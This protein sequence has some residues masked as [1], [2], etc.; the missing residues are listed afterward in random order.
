MGNTRRKSSVQ[1]TGGEKNSH[2]ILDSMPLKDSPLGEE[3]KKKPEKKRLEKKR[4]PV[5]RF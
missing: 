5:I 2:K 4:V 1:L 3:E